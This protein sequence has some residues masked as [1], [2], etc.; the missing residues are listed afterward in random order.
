[1][2]TTLVDVCNRALSRIGAVRISALT[3]TS[4]SAK[5]AAACFP[6]VPD[7]VLRS[8]R[9]K[10]AIKRQAI[11]APTPADETGWAWRYALPPDCLALAVNGDAGLLVEGS[12]VLSNQDEPSWVRFVTQVTDPAQWDPA[13][14][15]ALS[16][17]I[18]MEVQ[19]ELAP[20]LSALTLLNNFRLA[21]REA[22][23]SGAIEPAV[24]EGEVATNWDASR[25]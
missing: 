13:F 25:L 12:V 15:E 10:F 18:A 3:D 11:T 5:A 16:W 9:W 6:S 4:A 23:R 24:S 20:T 1:M 8:W 7:W 21:I 14:A 17:K 2:G 22:Q 19:P